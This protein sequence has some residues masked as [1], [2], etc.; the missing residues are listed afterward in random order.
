MEKIRIKGKQMI[1]Q[2]TKVL[3]SEISETNELLDQSTVD[4]MLKD[5]NIATLIGKINRAVAARELVVGTDDTNLTDKAKEIQERFNVAKFNRIFKH[6]LTA[7]Y[8]GYSLFEKVYDENYNLSSL[9]FI[10]QSFINY[11]TKEGWYIN[12]SNTKE[13]INK[14]KY[15]LCIHER[16]VANKKGKSILD[17]CLQSYTD[18]KMYSAQLRGLAKKYG[19]SIIFFGYDDTE[20]ETDVKKK[21]EEIKKVQGTEQ[22]VIGVPTSMG[23]ALKDS[24]YIL[25]LKDIDPTIYMKMHDWEYEKLTQYLLGGTLT[26]NNGG[27]KGSYGLGEIH[28][29]GF[30]EVIEDCCNFI[31]DKLQELL[32]YDAYFFGYDYRNFYFKLEKTKNRDELIDYELKRED[33]KAK[34]LANQGK[35]EIKNK[36]SD[37]DGI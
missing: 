14:D 16:D 10:P 32:Y 13:Y 35:G 5:I 34:Q 7:R 12:A 9:V 18:K 2:F 31:T 23:I 22:T 33:L 4:E 19:E 30:D 25:D 1:E 28:K 20:E 11:D 17:K 29:E 24:L 15:F 37:I 26:I 3:F 21:A 36:D 8:Y 27:G 6:I